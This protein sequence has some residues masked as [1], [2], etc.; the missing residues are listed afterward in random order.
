MAWHPDF[1]ASDPRDSAETV[2]MSPSSAS[3]RLTHHIFLRLQREGLKPYSHAPAEC[4]GQQVHSDVPSCL[5]PERSL[6]GE[7]NGPIGDRAKGRSCQEGLTS[8]LQFILR[9]RTLFRELFGDE[10]G[11]RVRPRG[12][13]G[14]FMTR[15]RRNDDLPTLEQH[16]RPISVPDHN[17]LS[18]GS[19]PRHWLSPPWQK[20][21]LG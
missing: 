19:P 3:S 14:V 5:L 11:T 8:F 1:T 6:S 13:L 12:I 18:G 2:S 7:S 20:P 15:C 21:C 9:R 16:V 4:P 10:P 17:V